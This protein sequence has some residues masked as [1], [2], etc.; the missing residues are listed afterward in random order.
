MVQVQHPEEGKELPGRKGIG[1]GLMPFLEALQQHSQE[2]L[3]H[4]AT[5]GSNSLGSIRAQGFFHLWLADVECSF[6][7]YAKNAG[8]KRLNVFIWSIFKAIGFVK[9]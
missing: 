4:T 2:S 5:K 9:I 1:E 7:R 8:S 3:G 6:M